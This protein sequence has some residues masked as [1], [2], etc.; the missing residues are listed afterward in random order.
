MYYIIIII[1]KSLVNSAALKK[2]RRAAGICHS[3]LRNRC[4]F[5]CRA[6][7]AVDSDERR[8][9]V[10]RLFQMY[11]LETAKFARPICLFGQ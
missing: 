4:A 5:R 7:V 2:L 9:S 3:V 6:K 8:R 1:I 11:G 10:G